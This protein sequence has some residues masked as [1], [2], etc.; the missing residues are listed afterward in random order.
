MQ[1]LLVTP[2]SCAR[3]CSSRIDRRL[4]P[5]AN[6]LNKV[7][8]NHMTIGPE[9]YLSLSLFFR[10]ERGSFFY[11]L[12]TTRVHPT[13]TPSLTYTHGTARSLLHPRIRINNNK[14]GESPI[15]HNQNESL[16][17]SL[18]LHPQSKQLHHPFVFGHSSLSPSL[19]F[20]YV[21]SSSSP[22]F[23]LSMSDQSDK[24]HRRPRRRLLVD[25]DDDEDE[26]EQLHKQ[27]HN[28]LQ[29]NNSH[30]ENNSFLQEKD[31]RKVQFVILG[32]FAKWYRRFFRDSR[33]E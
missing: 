16:F 1:L 27:N 26:V 17:L 32:S 30:Y 9:I 13:P 10:E 25:E 20:L 11:A 23:P 2:W 33:D 28:P 21:L 15:N 6:D 12:F 22:S 8:I 29:R 18:S 7:C 5:R 4:F 3:Q 19:S 31:P 24:H 14:T